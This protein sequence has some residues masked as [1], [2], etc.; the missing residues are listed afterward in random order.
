MVKLLLLCVI[1]YIYITYY[2]L[3]IDDS[4]WALLY[5]K[6]PYRVNNYLYFV[7]FVFSV[8]VYFGETIWKSVAD[9]HLEL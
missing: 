1:C 5:S 4:K 6:H 2:I 7:I 8:Y 9:M 3:Y